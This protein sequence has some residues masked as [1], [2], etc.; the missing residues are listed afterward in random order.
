MFCIFV[1]VIILG[2]LVFL[3]LQLF[4]TPWLKTN[5]KLP[6]G[7]LRGVWRLPL[8]MRWAPGLCALSSHSVRLIVASER[9]DRHIAQPEL[10]LLHMG[11]SSGLGGALE[12]AAYL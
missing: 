3:Y 8:H 12:T 7:V 11:F 5:R 4:L 10:W 6:D 2:F 9:L 1:N